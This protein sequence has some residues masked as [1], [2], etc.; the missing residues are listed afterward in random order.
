MGH[1]FTHTA[2]AFNSQ[3]CPSNRR[4]SSSWKLLEAKG[5]YKV[6]KQ[7]FLLAGEGGKRSRHATSE[8]PPHPF[9]PPQLPVDAV[10]LASTRKLQQSSHASQKQHRIWT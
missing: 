4:Q 6:C 1:K 7:F 9:F 10:S 8:F 5:T 2:A 3:M